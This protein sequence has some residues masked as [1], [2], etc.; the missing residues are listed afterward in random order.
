MGNG[1]SEDSPKFDDV[2]RPWESFGPGQLDR[3][4]DPAGMAPFFASENLR[5]APLPTLVLLYHPDLRRIGE[6]CSLGDLTAGR[7]VELSRLD[8]VFYTPACYLTNSLGDGRISRTPVTL[9]MDEQGS[10]DFSFDGNRVRLAIGDVACVSG[11]RVDA[12]QLARGVILNL[13]DAVLLWLG[14]L[15]PPDPLRP[16]HG[17]I[18][19]SPA[20]ARLR[21]DIDAV[22]RHHTPVLIRGETGVGKELVAR[23]IHAASLRASRPFLAVN[24]AAVAPSAAASELF[25]HK[26]GAFTD[27]VH[28]HDG[29][30]GAA[31]TGTL[32]MDEI[33]ETP[34]AVQPLLLRALNDRQIQPVG[35][36]PHAVD[37]RLITATDADLEREVALGRFR[38]ALLHR[39]AAWTIDVPP[40][41]QRRDTIPVLFM[42]FLARQLAD[43][44]ASHRVLPP[45]MGEL[46]WLSL[47]QMRELMDYA[48]PGNIRQLRN[49]A[50]EMAIRSSSH[51]V[52]ELPASLYR[53]FPHHRKAPS[54]GH[55]FADRRA[56]SGAHE[57]REASGP[58]G[59]R[60]LGGPGRLPSSPREL[61]PLRSTGAFEVQR[62]PP[63]RLSDDQVAAAL[64]AA[65]FNI[66]ATA[67]D[68]RIAK[69][70]L[71]ARM[72]TITALPRAADLDRRSIEAALA[73]RG[74]SLVAA[75]RHLRVGEHALRL[76]LAEL[77]AEA[78]GGPDRID[79]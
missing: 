50:S 19:F 60:E 77:A 47:R 5:A 59:S 42:H 54:G 29:Y 58:G 62:T 72:A 4:T 75:A 6:A 64:E 18:G 73:I 1:G 10:V 74:G 26:R 55:E 11:H 32:F 51:A 21:D 20:M 67:R 35:G 45:P 36:A 78:C 65:D 15:P 48:W 43:L 52:A 41:R 13:Q 66:S 28:A 38:D 49:L 3:L 30:F 79:D 44:G 71:V 27:A 40:L 61:D 17:M 24:M 68:L 12:G 23:A 25:G 37:L 57:R 16:D 8:P 22:S 39:I 2:S 31:H 33:G 9:R 56:P 63:G 53:P 7:P 69:N 46:P 34:Q 70:S 14:W 76:R